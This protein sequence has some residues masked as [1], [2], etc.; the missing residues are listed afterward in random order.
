M[1]ATELR[2]WRRDE[3]EKMIANGLFAPG[4]RVELI[5]GDILKLNPQ[6]SFHATAV[7]LVEDS[8]RS[9]FGAGFDVRAQLPVALGT[10]SEPEPDVAVVTGSPRDYRE[11]HPSTAVLIVEVA[12][13][14]LEYDRVRKG[15]VYARAGI[16][17]YWLV[18]LIDRCVEV[19]RLPHQGAYQTITRFLPGDTISPM[20]AAYARLAVADVL[21]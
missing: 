7:R 4:E 6:G 21:P 14:T 1:K 3:Y 5:E 12:D 19:Y 2:P 10:H 13:T 20:A 15:A 17:E 11:T 16:P 18:N 8:L 9:I